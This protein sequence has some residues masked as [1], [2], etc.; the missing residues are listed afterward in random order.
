VSKRSRLIVEF[1][2]ENTRKVAILK[3]R[4]ESKRAH[5][6]DGPK[7]RDDEDA[8]EVSEGEPIVDAAGANKKINNDVGSKGKAVSKKDSGP[9]NQGKRKA[10]GGAAEAAADGPGGHKKQRKDDR[11][12]TANG[13]KDKRDGGKKKH[14]FRRARNR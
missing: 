4:L 3:K 14:S 2:L 8:D 6:A 5:S 10:E 1:S 12:N 11:Q 13:R 7:P 9:G